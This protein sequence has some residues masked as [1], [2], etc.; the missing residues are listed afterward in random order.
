MRPR[1]GA[2]ARSRTRCAAWKWTERPSG[3]SD[4]RRAPADRTRHP[5]LVL[6]PLRRRLRRRPGPLPHKIEGQIRGISRMVTADR[7]CM[8]VLTQITHTDLPP[9]V[10]RP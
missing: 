9:R 5:L 2:A 1:P 4:R 10:Y 6:R 7:Y 8:D 3:R